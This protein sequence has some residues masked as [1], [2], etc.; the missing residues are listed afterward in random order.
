M[1]LGISNMPNMTQELL[2]RYVWKETKGTVT[3]AANGQ[4]PLVAMDKKKQWQTRFALAVFSLQQQ[5][6]MHT[7]KGKDYSHVEWYYTPLPA[8]TV[9]AALGWWNPLREGRPRMLGK[10]LLDGLPSP[11]PGKM[12]SWKTTGLMYFTPPIVGRRSS[13]N[14]TSPSGLALLRHWTKTFPAFQKHFDAYWSENAEKEITLDCID[15]SL[16]TIPTR[17]RKQNEAN[18]RLRAKLLQEKLKADAFMNAQAMQQ[19]SY[20]RAQQYTSG[21]DNSRLA[22]AQQQSPYLSGAVAQLQAKAAQQYK[23]ATMKT[24]DWGLLGNL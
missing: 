6:V 14:R 19:A 13:R 1:G 12:N 20:A 5:T 4:L 23:G 17:F 21:L 9:I 8:D 24:K 16:G 11:T 10:A 15:L 3:V 7:R 2:D 22:S 18:D